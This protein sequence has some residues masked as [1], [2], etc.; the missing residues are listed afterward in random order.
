MGA[1]VSTTMTSPTGGMACA[2]A[3][4]ARTAAKAAEATT[5]LRKG[6]FDEVGSLEARE[7]WLF[8]GLVAGM[9]R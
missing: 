7:K 5:D 8:L 4:A 1:T 6:I 3:V 2:E 9:N